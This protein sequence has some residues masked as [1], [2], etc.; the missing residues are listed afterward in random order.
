MNALDVNERYILLHKQDKKPQGPWANVYVYPDEVQRHIKWG[1]NIGVKT[2]NGLVVIDVDNHDGGSNGFD[3]L[4]KLGLPETRSVHTPS[5]GLHLYYSCDTPIKN[6]TSKLAPGIDVRGEGG[7]VVCPPSV[8]PNGAYTWANDGPIAGLPRHI[9]EVLA[10]PKPDRKVP[11]KNSGT[12]GRPSGGFFDAAMAGEALAIIDAAF[13]ERNHTLNRSAYKL[14][15]YTDL[16]EEQARMCL[17]DAAIHSGLSPRE[18]NASFSSGWQAGRQAPRDVKSRPSF[19]QAGD[20]EKKPIETGT[21]LQAATLWA[22]GRGKDFMHHSGRGWLAWTGTHWAEGEKLAQYSIQEHGRDLTKLARAEQDKDARKE[23]ERMAKRCQ[24]ESGVRAVLAMASSLPAC[25]GDLIQWDLSGTMLATPTGTIDIET[26]ALCDARP[27]DYL[28]RCCATE[29]VPLAK[30][31]RWEQFLEEVFEGDAE[32]IQYVQWLA[33]LSITGLTRHHVF[34]VCHGSGANGKS[35]FLNT[36]QRVL[37]RDLAHSLPADVILEQRFAPHPE[38]LA[39][40]DGKRMA[41]VEETPTNGRLNEARLKSLSAGDPQRARLMR[42]NSYEF[43]PVCTIWIGTNHLPRV[44]DASP[45]FWRRMRAIPF[46]RQFSGKDCDPGLGEKL[47]AE[48]PGVL[49]WCVGGARR[50]IHEGEPGLPPRVAG[51]IEHYRSSED[52]VQEFLDSECDRIAEGRAPVSKV[53]ERFL[54]FHGGDCET[55]REFGR[56]LESM[57]YERIKGT[58]GSRCWRGLALREAE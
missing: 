39:A 15:G 33:G 54:D 9:L 12:N 8:L 38:A 46:S 28:T 17:V 1:G 14:G 5:G 21:E 6:S 4:D 47:L 50:V 35:T 51:A 42:Q 53:Y 41:I 40:L 55:Q 43:V 19:T 2:G 22:N 7:Y 30:A 13:G 20:G 36:L 29:Y 25:N 44:A 52:S 57:G 32:L 58:G 24:S 26:S 27:K 49:G 18:A 3:A 23:L 37:G 34:A 10:E 16:D 48:A 56:R 31:P 45:G 11:T